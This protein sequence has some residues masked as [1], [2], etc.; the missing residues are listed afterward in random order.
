MLLVTAPAGGGSA[1]AR[2]TGGHASERLA[3]EGGHR[4]DLSRRNK[5]RF[6][7]SRFR[8]DEL[9][10]IQAE[11]ELTLAGKHGDVAG[12]SI[13]SDCIDLNRKSHFLHHILSRPSYIAG[14]GG[15]RG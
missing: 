10:V 12:I 14:G 13:N 11:L 4:P 9:I 8:R 5:G 1:A 6:S 3:R 7:T 2:L 15:R